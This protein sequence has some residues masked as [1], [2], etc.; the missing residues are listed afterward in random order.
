MRTLNVKIKNTQGQ[1]KLIHNFYK[2]SLDDI[3]DSNIDNVVAS[4]INTNLSL[5]IQITSNIQPKMVLMFCYHYSFLIR[6]QAAEIKTLAR[7]QKK[8]HH[9]CCRQ[10]LY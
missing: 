6:Q 4:T 8:V 3:L 10:V 5:L 2:N 1:I 9:L 7:L